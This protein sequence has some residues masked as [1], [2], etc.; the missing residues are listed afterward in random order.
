MD[1][2]LRFIGAACRHTKVEVRR[3][4]ILPQPTGTE[5]VASV[6]MVLFSDVLAGI[7]QLSASIRGILRAV[8]SN[9]TE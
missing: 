6:G 8:C 1:V 4:M 3:G 2:Q 9:M 7:L 5:F